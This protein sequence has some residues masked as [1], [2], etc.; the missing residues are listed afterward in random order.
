[1]CKLTNNGYKLKDGTIV[2]SSE[3]LL[4]LKQSQ[5]NELYDTPMSAYEGIAI[6]ENIS[7]LNEAYTKMSNV[8]TGMDS[9]LDKTLTELKGHTQNCPIA[10]TKVN[11]MIED[12]FKSCLN[13]NTVN[14]FL[15]HKWVEIL[16]SK[17]LSIGKVAG[18]VLTILALIGLIFGLSDFLKGV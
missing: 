2:N 16:K 12:K 9:K 1:M 10:K 5:T 4:K 8:V 3:D 7:K 11:E 17:V 18:A 14:E 6:R 15:E 13:K